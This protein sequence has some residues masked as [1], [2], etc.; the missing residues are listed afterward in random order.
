MNLEEE[1]IS[2]FKVSPQR[3]QVW[4]TQLEMVKIFIDICSKY[5]FKYVASG[6]TLLGAIRHNGYIPWDD[7]I[8][9]MMPRDDY[10]TFLKIAQSELPEN[11]FL[12]C[13]RTER[14]Y[15]N[16]HAQMRNNN[17]TCFIGLSYVD[18]KKGKNCGIFIDIFPYDDVPDNI[19]AR[20]KQAR[21]IKILK[22]LCIYRI[23][24]GNGLK[25]FIKNIIQGCY[26]SFHSAEKTIKKIDAI[27]QKYNHKTNTVALVSFMPGYE[28][29]VWDKDWFNETINCKFEDI[30]IAI[31]VKF[32]EVLRKEFGDYMRI[33]KN[34]TS[35]NMHGECFF[36]TEKSYKEYLEISHEE[37]KD[38]ISNLVL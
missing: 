5:H 36:D 25:G 9:L 8:D 24:T 27:S 7:D 18:L 19:K 30:E 6:G 32:D 29:N 2:G 22:K 14:N 37:F 21:K 4:N 1:I 26:F 12:Q 17:T 38:I 28:K 13:Y 34:K 31:P 23:Y 35:G 20:N 33:P 10:E 3:K 11:M 15:P 16:G